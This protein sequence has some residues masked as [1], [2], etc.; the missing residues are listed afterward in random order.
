MLTLLPYVRWFRQHETLDRLNIQAHKNAMNSS[1]EYVMDSFVTFDKVGHNKDTHFNLS[2]ISSFLPQMK[3]LIY[4]LLCTEVWKEKLYPLLIPS[5][6][7]INSVRS[8][9]TVS[10]KVPEFSRIL[11]N[12]NFIISNNPFLHSS[13]RFTTK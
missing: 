8:Y 7:K 9:M 1:D 5:L 6:T 3:V 12:P 4:D 2:N 11:P 10:T 13:F